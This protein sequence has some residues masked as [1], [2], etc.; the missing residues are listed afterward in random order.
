MHGERATS[1]AASKR[2]RSTS[3]LTTACALREAWRRAIVAHGTLEEAKRPCGTPL[4]TSHAYALLEMLRHSGSMTVSDLASCLAIDRSNV[5]RLCIRME[6]AGEI[7]RHEY[8]DDGRA[9][10]LTL[11]A[12]GRRLARS[13]DEASTE[14]F[15][16][17]SQRLGDSSKQVIEALRLLQQAMT[18]TK[19]EQ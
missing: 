12:A 8:S 15:L 10:A 13:V 1:K 3:D 9:C 5:S 14:H 17:L 16:T 4:K 6:K 11:T 19:D 18:E 2:S 7:E